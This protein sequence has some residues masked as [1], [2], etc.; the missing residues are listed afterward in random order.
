MRYLT[1]LFLTTI[2]S[3]TCFG[4]PLK[5]QWDEYR[6]GWTDLM[7]AIYIDDLRSVSQLLFDGADVNE[8]PTDYRSITNS[9]M[10]V[11]IYKQNEKSVKILLETKSVE[12]LGEHLKIA[13]RHQNAKIVRLLLEAGADPN[14]SYSN[15]S[16]P[17]ACAFIS[18]NLEILSA[19]LEYGADVNVPILHNDI[20]L[21]MCFADRGSPEHVKLL[22]KFGA[23][24]YQRDK[25]FKSA[26][27]YI[28]PSEAETELRNLLAIN[29]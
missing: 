1:A 5:I 8:K 3:S 18:G 2:L 26:Y 22:L 4:Q 15:G 24:K 29:Q 20:T 10:E 6:D 12:N 16:I 21:L 17:L 19:L 7:N 9:A 13:A 14:F 28:K 23:N 11:A 25:E 27:D